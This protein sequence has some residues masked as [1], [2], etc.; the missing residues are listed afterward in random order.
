M[1]EDIREIQ[2]REINAYRARV[3]FLS[4]DLCETKEQIQRI[5]LLIQLADSVTTLL[6]LESN[7]LAREE[8]EKQSTVI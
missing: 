7:V 2:K 4:Q 5:N 8:A 3:Q 6:H 1:S